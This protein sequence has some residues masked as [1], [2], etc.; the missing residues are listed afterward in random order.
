MQDQEHTEQGE[1]SGLTLEDLCGGPFAAD[2]MR[3]VREPEFTASVRSLHHELE[4]QHQWLSNMKVDF[5]QRWDHRER[6][7]QEQPPYVN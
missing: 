7:M 2:Y 1:P 3:H 4:L 5:N 6:A